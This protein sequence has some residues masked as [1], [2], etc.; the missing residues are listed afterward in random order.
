VRQAK[1]S[2]NLQQNIGNNIFKEQQNVT[3]T[4]SNITNL[5]SWQLNHQT[6]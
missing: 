6:N 5:I 1:P 3:T 4:L 2:V